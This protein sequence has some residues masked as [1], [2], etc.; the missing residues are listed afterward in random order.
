MARS[1]R[2]A[3]IKPGV[4]FVLA[5][6]YNKIARQNRRMFK[7]LERI[8]NNPDCETATCGRASQKIVAEITSE[9][10]AKP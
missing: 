1:L 5:T 4:R 6:E 10:E 9:T 8:A 7:V 3:Q 2:L